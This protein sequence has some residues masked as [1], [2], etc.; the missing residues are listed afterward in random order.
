MSNFAAF[1]L[2]HQSNAFPMHGLT[3]APLEFTSASTDPLSHL[4]NALCVGDIVFGLKNSHIGAFGLVADV[5][6][7]GKRYKDQAWIGIDFSPATSVT[8]P[9]HFAAEIKNVM[10]RTHGE[11]SGLIQLPP[12]LG[13]ALNLLVPE[14]F[15]HHQKFGCRSAFAHAAHAQRTRILLERH[16]ISDAKK[17]AL[18]E[19][20]NGQGKFGE[21]VRSHQPV[22]PFVQYETADSKVVH[23][24]PWDNCTDEQ[25]L[26]PENGILLGAEYANYF[27]NGYISFMENGQ[28][29]FSGALED[30]FRTG[31]RGGPDNDALTSISEVQQTYLEYHRTYV[32]EHWRI[33][34]RMVL[35]DLPKE[36]LKSEPGWI[37]AP[38]GEG[39]IFKER[40]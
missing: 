34:S 10:D 13:E 32:F 39:H 30:R 36:M 37:P 11:P 2:T 40:G 9:R 24:R 17:L 6:P 7:A 26:D 29:C 16:D 15:R 33:Q 31:S 27:T 12:L 4:T 3:Y 35:M 18:L 20:L 22:C 19:A 28:Y 38:S 25:R 8:L 5:Q 21:A 1:D 14:W 23:I